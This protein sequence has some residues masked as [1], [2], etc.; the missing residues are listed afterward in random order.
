MSSLRRWAICTARSVEDETR[1][2]R[3]NANR[4]PEWWGD[5]SQLV[6]IE[7]LKFM[8]SHGTN[9]LW[10]FDWI[11][12]PLCLP[13][14]IQIVIL[15]LQ[16]TKI[17]PPFRISICISTII[18]SLIFHG[19][20]CTTLTHSHTHMCDFKTSTFTHSYVWLQDKHSHRD[21]ETFTET[22]T[23]SHTHVCDLKTST[24]F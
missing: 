15:D 18:P 8:V 21:T 24:H 23:H 6:E 4:N 3:W 10:D 22:L 16:L 11:W 20:G 1:N 9:S 14:H 7:K 13:V 5:F 12:I 19:T 2:D 17:S